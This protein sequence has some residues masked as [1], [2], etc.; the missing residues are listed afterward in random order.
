MVL[1][2][3]IWSGLV[4]TTLALA[5]FWVARSLRWTEFSPTVQLGSLII[6]DPRKPITETVGFLL[7]LVLGTTLL[8]LLFGWL[9]RFWGGPAWLGGLVIGGF[10]GIAVA[11]LLSLVGTGSALVRSGAFSPPGPFGIGWG[12]PTP[13]VILAGSMLYGALV[14]AVLAGF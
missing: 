12:R 1:S 3:L 8:P 6:P 13:A 14:A 5:F 10:A 9:L 4:A 11:G 2:S 7:L